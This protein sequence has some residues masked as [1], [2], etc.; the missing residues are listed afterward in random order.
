MPKYNFF[1][2]LDFLAYLKSIHVAYTP[3]RARTEVCR[4]LIKHFEDPQTVKRF[5]KLKAS[6][7]I[8]GYDSPSTVHLELVNG[9]KHRFLAER[10][11]MKEMQLMFD[12]DQFSAHLER[13]KKQSLETAPE[14]DD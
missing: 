1:P 10:F 14:D 6:Y 9:K 2:P 12:N 3:G 7:Q 4:Q 8:L 5:P 11:S 13:M